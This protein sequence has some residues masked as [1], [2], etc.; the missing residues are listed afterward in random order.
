MLAQ[1]FFL[2][3]NPGNGPKFYVSYPNDAIGIIS[4]NSAKITRQ[5]RFVLTINTKPC[6]LFLVEVQA[7]GVVT[8]IF[9]QN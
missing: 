9:A 8:G 3:S 7:A 2:L 1:L 6:N 4:K 5:A